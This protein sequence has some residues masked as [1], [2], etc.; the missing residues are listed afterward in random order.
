MSLTDRI[1]RALTGL[2][3]DHPP[4]RREV[5]A[6]LRKGVREEM[7]HAATIKR[8]KRNPQMPVR[9]VAEAIAKDHIKEDPRYYDKLAAVDKATKEVK[10]EMRRA[11]RLPKL[12]PPR[13]KLLG[14][15]GK[16]KIYLVDATY[17]R[18]MTDKNPNAPDFTM[19]TG[20][21]VWPEVTGPWE[22][23]V[24]DELGPPRDSLEMHLT[25]IHEMTERRLML[26]DGLS[27][28]EAHEHALAVEDKYRKANGRGLKQALQRERGQ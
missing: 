20:D 16:L 9:A 15:R 13:I 4:T 17:V 23:W 26:R 18:G 27:Y 22:V 7:E 12:K 8:V 1:N 10:Q 25:M 19:G 6:Q 11:K 28:D 3:S 2:L 14:R 21:Q 5:E 24:S